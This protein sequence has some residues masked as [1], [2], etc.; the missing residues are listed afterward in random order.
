MVTNN[1]YK[2]LTRCLQDM[3]TDYIS[4]RVSN[5]IAT[6]KK[7]LQTTNIM[8]LCMPHV[9]K[10]TYNKHVTSCGMASCK[11]SQDTVNVAQY[12]TRQ[13]DNNENE[14]N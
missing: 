11:P 4:K 3:F 10:K 2:T 8:K 6:P 1:S 5:M 13:Q 7:E 9:I 12:F 14:R